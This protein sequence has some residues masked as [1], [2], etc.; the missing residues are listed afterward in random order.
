MLPSP[1]RHIPP[2][3]HTHSRCLSVFHP[4]PASLI[5]VCLKSS[6]PQPLY[7]PGLSSA[8]FPH[9]F[10]YYCCRCSTAC[11]PH[12]YIGPSLLFTKFSGHTTHPPSFFPSHLLVLCS[13][14]SSF[15][16]LGCQPSAPLLLPSSC[17][18][19]SPFWLY[20]VFLLFVFCLPK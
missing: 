6:P 20:S 4:L 18:H 9:H 12:L 14:P 16:H 1:L 7:P 19:A 2:V 10:S 17:S 15:P 5:S 8:Q 11:I 3:V 13:C